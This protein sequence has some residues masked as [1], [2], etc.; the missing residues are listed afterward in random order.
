MVCIYYG[1]TVRYGLA[2][3]RYGTV[4]SSNCTGTVPYRTVPYKVPV[5]YYTVF[6]HAGHIHTREL[7]VLVVVISKKIW[8]SDYKPQ[9]V[10]QLYIIH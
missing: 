1:S 9:Y 7:D 3:V 8:L 2:T 5:R 4:E 10:S 6:Y